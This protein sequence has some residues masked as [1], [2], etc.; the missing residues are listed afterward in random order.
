MGWIL[1]Y[2]QNASKR[3]YLCKKIFKNMD[4]R[5]S[6]KWCRDTLT[7]GGVEMEE[8]STLEMSRFT[9]TGDIVIMYQGNVLF[10]LTNNRL[11][12]WV[13]PIKKHLGTVIKSVEIRSF[14]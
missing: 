3:L 12:V 11:T 9:G 10:S 14:K 13:N 4:C 5:T 2:R 8:Q 6:K 7:K 1:F